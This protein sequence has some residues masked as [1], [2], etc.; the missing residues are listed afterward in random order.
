MIELKGVNKFY[1]NF[2]ALYDVSFKV[3][4]GEILGFLGPN[5]AGKTT[6]MR[7]ITG[8][9]PPSDGDCIVDGISILDN[10]IEV[11]KRIGY[12]PENPPLYTEFT[13]KEYLYF[14]GKLKG[15]SKKEVDK[16]IEDIVEKCGIKDVYGK[17]I[18]KLSKGYRQRVGI[19]QALLH[20][21]R[22]I[23]LDEPTIGLDPVQIREIRSLIKGLGGDHTVILSSHILP[24]VSQVCDRILII[25]KGKIVAEDT[26]EN[27]T[28]KLK[29]Q[30]K[31]TMVLKGDA[32]KV[33]EILGKYTDLIEISGK[34]ELKVNF[35]LKSDE[36]LRPAIIRDI[37]ENG[38]A[39]IYEF[40]TEKLTLEDIFVHL[41]TEENGGRE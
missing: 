5:G 27:L 29:G 10:P 33:K 34:E 9:M 39:D 7:I 28:K 2:Q 35:E 25:N 16:R 21:P 23:I 8:F 11:K 31:C 13:V 40:F 20:D 37:I 38:S 19:A 12:L 24:E 22:V 3:N 32:E 17:V 15:L 14:V 30:T 26:P 6:T 36:D 4:E 41:V 18:S 1:G